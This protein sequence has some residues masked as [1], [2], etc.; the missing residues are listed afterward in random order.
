MRHHFRLRYAGLVIPRSH[1]LNRTVSLLSFVPF[2][3][4]VS[5]ALACRCLYYW[6]CGYRPP[7]PQLCIPSA[8]SAGTE[9]FS[10]PLCPPFTALHTATTALLPTL[11]DFAAT[12]PFLSSSLPT[13]MNNALVEVICVPETYCSKN[14]Y[15]PPASCGVS[16]KL[17]GIAPRVIASCMSHLFLSYRL[18][19]LSPTSSLLTQPFSPPLSLG[20][21]IPQGRGRLLQ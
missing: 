14:V 10:R 18:L 13:D 19:S 8:S 9:P 3:S 16:I 21:R 20:L 7:L 6:S 15:N 5:R 12:C 17:C 11:F 2:L 1:V 4:F